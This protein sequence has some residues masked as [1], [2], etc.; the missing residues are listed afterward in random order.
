MYFLNHRSD[1]ADNILSAIRTLLQ[2]APLGD[3]EEEEE[4]EGEGEEGEAEKEPPLDREDMMIV[5]AL[6]NK[7]QV[8]SIEKK[9]FFPQKRI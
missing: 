2:N 9:L 6:P 4:G 7:M 8:S 3:D 1:I 5:E